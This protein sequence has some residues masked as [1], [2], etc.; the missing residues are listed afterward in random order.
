MSFRVVDVLVLASVSNVVAVFV[1][2]R[3]GE[4]LPA[5]GERLGYG[6]DPFGVVDV[7]L[8]WG[9]GRG[10][11]GLDGGRVGCLEVRGVV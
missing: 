9:L 1:G 3:A 10:G 7:G 2:S 4:G 5:K 11:W 6:V 8:A